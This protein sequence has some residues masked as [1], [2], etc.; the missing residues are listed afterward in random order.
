MNERPKLWL[1]DLMGRK[2]KV[3]AGEPIIANIPLSGA[4]TPTIEWS[5]GGIRLPESNRISAETTRCW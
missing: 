5:K 1:D 4:P 2:I 3:R